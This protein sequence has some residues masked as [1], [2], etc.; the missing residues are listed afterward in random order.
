MD[1]LQCVY[2]FMMLLLYLG[3][4][5]CLIV[6]VLARGY[7]NIFC[8]AILGCLII[9]ETCALIV[10]LRLEQ[11]NRVYFSIS[12]IT[13]FRFGK[14][15]CDLPWDQV[16]EVGIK[17]WSGKDEHDRLRTGGQYIYFADHL[18]TET[19]R[20][21]IG[22]YHQRNM[23][24]NG[25]AFFCCFDYLLNED[26]YD[27]AYIDLKVRK[28]FPEDF[29]DVARLCHIC[30]IRHPY[31]GIECAYINIHGLFTYTKQQFNLLATTEIRYGK[32]CVYLTIVA[33][34]FIISPIVILLL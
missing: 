5:A 30:K 6:A 22:S 33:A 21:S 32:R 25:I 34:L 26:S 23:A 31:E 27:G 10:R 4:W 3:F 7:L 14:K 19:E 17:Y 29:F 9:L 13:V 20:I 16:K 28:F 8:I 18:L 2:A 12:G 1:T 15:I 11:F 24:Q